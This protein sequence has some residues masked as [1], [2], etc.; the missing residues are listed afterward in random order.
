M[1]ACVLL[2]EVERPV[3][4]D[5]Q[6]LTRSK[7][8]SAQN[9]SHVIR[10]V[11]SSSQQM[12][13]YDHS[14]LPVS[15]RQERQMTPASPRP[16]PSQGGSPGAGTAGPS[17]MQLH[18]FSMS[19]PP[20]VDGYAC[21]AVKPEGTPFARSST[22]QANRDS[23]H[24]SH[25]P[26]SRY[27]TPDHRSLTPGVDHVRMDTHRADSGAISLATAPIV[28]P[29]HLPGH[30]AAASAAAVAEPGPSVAG[31]VQFS[32]L[33]EDKPRMI[34]LPLPLPAHPLARSQQHGSIAVGMPAQIAAPARIAATPD[35]AP[36]TPANAG[37]STYPGHEGV[38]VNDPRLSVNE[39]R[40]EEGVL[41]LLFTG[42]EKEYS[43]A[44]WC[45]SLQIS[46]CQ[47][48]NLSLSHVHRNPLTSCALFSQLFTEFVPSS[49]KT[50]SFYYCQYVHHKFMLL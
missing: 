10:L 30:P 12:V 32:E 44:Y 7:R 31:S 48:V 22:P 4:P 11:K 14:S 39:W 15:P 33:T 24:Q 2:Q 50:V 6:S 38:A 28:G 17:N 13:T 36:P 45:V 26:G 29:T 35:P 21:A 49:Y 37:T 3:H 19:P 43:D 27:A 25:T 47:S 18:P 40:S 41:G 8:A 9:V 16:I 34:A 1:G 42:S 20:V 46:C 5:E 23:P